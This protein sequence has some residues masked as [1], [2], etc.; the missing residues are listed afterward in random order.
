MRATAS[1]TR[2]GSSSSGGPD[3]FSGGNRAESAGTGADIAEN[4]KGRGTVFPTFPHVGAARAFANG[5]QI[6]GAHGALQVLIAFA[7]KNLTRS[8]SGRG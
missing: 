6:E 1:A 3:R 2:K 8:Q 7:A 5:V 4:H